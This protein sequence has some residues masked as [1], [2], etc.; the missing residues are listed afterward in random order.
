MSEALRYLQNRERLAGD[1]AAGRVQPTVEALAAAFEERGNED[2]FTAAN[3]AVK[4]LD[5]LQR[6]VERQIARPK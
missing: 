4:F 2:P 5:D 3:H 1:V 6:G